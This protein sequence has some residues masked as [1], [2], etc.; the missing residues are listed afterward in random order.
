MPTTKF[1][2]PNFTSQTATA[3]KCNLDADMQV[4]EILGNEFAPHQQDSPD[5][6]VRVEEGRILSPYGTG[7]GVHYIAAQNSPAM[8]AP[9]A[10]P[11]IDAIVLDV[12]SGAVSVITGTEAPS[13]PIPETPYGKLSIAAVLLQTTTTQITDSMIRDDRCIVTVDAKPMCKV[14]LN[15]DVAIS[16][17]TWTLIGWNAEE[18][19]AFGMHSVSV[20]PERITVPRAGKYRISVYTAWEVNATGAR[21]INIL[22]NSGPICSNYVSALA[23]W[24]TRHALSTILSLSVDDYVGVNV[25]QTS[26]GSLWLGGSALPSQYSFF[27]VEYL[28]P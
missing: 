14:Y 19:D 21:G 13:P 16:N 26:G 7:L 1:V 8:A 15:A 24:P 28:G 12:V 20:N 2:Q 23:V 25:I 10:N 3:Y 5:M 22:Y 11:R 18:F 27:E 17:D 9:A 4:L 6:T